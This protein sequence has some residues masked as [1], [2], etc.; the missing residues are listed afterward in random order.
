MVASRINL[1]PDREVRQRLA[2]ATAVARRLEQFIVAS[3]G[4][5]RDA[6]T[7]QPG[8]I[9]RRIEDSKQRFSIE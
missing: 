5:D 8:A 9:R 1:L 2:H 7:E 6:A 3:E 4:S